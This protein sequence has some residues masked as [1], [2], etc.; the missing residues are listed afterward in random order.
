MMSRLKKAIFKKLEKLLSP[1]VVL[2]DLT[3]YPRFTLRK[4]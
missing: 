2:Q 1:I 3:L 4:H